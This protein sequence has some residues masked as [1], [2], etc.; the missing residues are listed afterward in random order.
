MYK[1]TNEETKEEVHQSQE[2]NVPPVGAVEKEFYYV[3]AALTDQQKE[4]MDSYFDRIMVRI[5]TTKKKSL[6]VG[7]IIGGFG[8]IAGILV[9]ALIYFNFLLWGS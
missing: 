9:S 7:I 4:V 8:S 3:R 1:E 2:I 6:F 5:N